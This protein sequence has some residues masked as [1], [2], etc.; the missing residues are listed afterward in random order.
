MPCLLAL[1]GAFFPRVAFLFF[2]IARPVLV[3]DAFGSSWLLPILGVVFLPFTTLV[4]VLLY[5]PGIGVVGLGWFWVGLAFLIDLSHWFGAYSQR[6]Y[7]TRY[8][9]GAGV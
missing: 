9:P 3:S 4:Y 5:H 7:V 6:R 1:F 8:S 2:W